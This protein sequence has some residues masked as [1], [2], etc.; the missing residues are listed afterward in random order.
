MTIE[1]RAIDP[2]DEA[3]FR[4]GFTAYLEGAGAGRIDPPLWTVQE[5]LVSYGRPTS[6]QRRTFFV[7]YVDGSPAGGLELELPLKEN[8]QLAMFALAVAPRFRRQGVGTALYDH[9]VRLASEDGRTSLLTELF[10]PPE[11]DESVAVA[12]ATKRGFT[13]RN[14]EIRRQLAMPV[15]TDH[16]DKLAAKAAERAGDYRL[17]L[18]TGACPDEYASQYAQLK[19]LLMTEAPIGALDY[20]AEQWDVERLREGEAE[21]VAQGR[22][23][24]TAVALAADG[25][26][27]AHT[28][29]VVPSAEPGRAYQWDTLVLPE[30]RGHRLGLALKVANLR[31]LQA[32][33]PEIERITTWNAEQN[34]PMV[35]VNVELGFEI[36]ERL[37]EWQGNV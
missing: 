9:L 28:Q 29:A 13:C 11:A 19:G 25:S 16:L 18:W 12:F 26:V 24:Y 3:T 1:I 6:S 36:V 34:G 22:T 17:V 14:N 4:A 30:H 7:A 8:L 20:E 15:A 21:L 5:A 32:E 35:A 27:A 33:H 31:A 23:A 10:L 2:A 37:Q